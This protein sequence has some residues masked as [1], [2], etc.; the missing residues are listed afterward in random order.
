MSTAAAA[1][2]DNTEANLEA[3]FRGSLL[4]R[5]ART[6][7]HEHDNTANYLQLDE[8]VC[9]GCNEGDNSEQRLNSPTHLPVGRCNFLPA[10]PT[11]DPDRMNVCADDRR[12]DAIELISSCRQAPRCKLRAKTGTS[13]QDEQREEIL[14]RTVFPCTSIY[15][16]M[17]T[18]HYISESFGKGR[19]KL[20]SRR[21]G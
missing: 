6:E 20:H 13:L 19:H 21:D 15:M 17:Y 7:Q 3:R 10:L 14:T 11:R 4:L 5:F 8:H 1:T 16:Y 9:Q 18:S 12:K 2:C